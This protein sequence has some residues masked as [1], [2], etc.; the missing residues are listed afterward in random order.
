MA[1]VR[2]VKCLV[3]QKQMYYSDDPKWT[4]EYKINIVDERTHQHSYVHK[5]CWKKLMKKI[6]SNQDL[7][8]IL[9]V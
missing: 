6:K 1:L 8:K 7:D 3:C 2:P 9:G 5:P 4:P